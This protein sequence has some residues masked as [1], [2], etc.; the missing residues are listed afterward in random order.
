MNIVF[1]S[2]KASMAEGISEHGLIGNALGARVEACRQLLEGLFP[3]PR[4]KPPA[5]R[6]QLGRAVGGWPHDL[7][8]VSRRNIVVGLQIASGAVRE[9]VQILNVVPS[10][11]LNK[12]PAHAI[13]LSIFGNESVPSRL[14]DHDLAD[15]YRR[16]AGHDYSSS[17]CRKPSED[18]ASDHPPAEAVAVRKQLLGGAMRAAG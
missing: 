8:R 12:A 10:V 4:N 11:T 2:P 9:F 15:L 6:Y 16:V 13:S 1:A 7:Y 17:H 18:E 3:P 14:R 5:H